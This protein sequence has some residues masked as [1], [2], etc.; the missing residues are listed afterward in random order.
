MR[1][2]RLTKGKFVLFL[3]I[4]LFCGK[5]SLFSQEVL[6]T[7]GFGGQF[8]ADERI[9]YNFG[10]NTVTNGTTLG[11]NILFIGK[12][13]FAVSAGTDLT[14]SIGDGVNTDPILGFGYTYYN[15]FFIG[16]ILNLIP[17]PYIKFDR[18]GNGSN[19]YG[20]VFIAPTVV[21]GY[22]FG[23]IVIGGQLSYMIGVMS[24]VSGFRYSLI[25]GVNVLNKKNN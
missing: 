25:A 14:F 23:G 11:V 3:V 8:M 1:S 5:I 7:F 10:N 9:Y 19:W 15:S 24:K 17:K 22:D 16:G 6:A 12:S 21:A 13:G 2:L 4:Y 18:S 20:D